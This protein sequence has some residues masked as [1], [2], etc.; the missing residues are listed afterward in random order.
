M[1]SGPY[2]LFLGRY[3]GFTEIQKLAF[4]VIEGRT[5]CI[6]TAPTGSG[7]TESAVLPVLKKILESG[8]TEGIIVLYI[9]PL[10]ALNRDLIKRLEWLSK[11]VGVN[12]GV[13]HGDTSQKERK[14]QA[15]KPPVFLITTPET[16]QNLFMSE[17]LRGS[18]KNLEYVIVDEVHELYHNKRGAQLSVALERLEE[19]SHGF[20]RIGLSATIG[21]VED[22]CAFLFGERKYELIS[23]GKSKQFDVQIEMPT[24]SRHE[25][26]EFIERFE[27]DDS[28]YARIARLAELISKSNQTLIFANTRQVVESLGNKLLY[29]EKLEPFGSIGIHHSSID[30][31]ERIET[32]NAFKEGKVKSLIATSS[33]ELGIDIGKIDLVVQ[34]GSPRQVVR[35]MQRVGRAGHKEGAVSN[36]TIIVSDFVECIESMAIISA[37]KEREL[38]KQYIEYDA[39]DVLANQICGIVLEYKKIEI[40]KIYQIIKRATPYRDTKTEKIDKVIEFLNELKIIRKVDEKNLALGFR[41]RKY[42]INNISVIPDSNRFYVKTIVGNRII[43]SLDENFVFSYLDVGATFITKGLSWKVISIEEDKIYVEPAEDIEASVPDWEGE[44]I[45]VSYNVAQRVFKL[46]NTDLNA[47]Q[48]FTEKAALASLGKFLAAQKEYFVPSV[49]TIYVEELEN[50]AIIYIALGRSANEFLAR[51]LNT[52]IIPML[53]SVV[54][55]RASPYAIIIDYSNSSRRVD[56][57]RLFGVIEKFDYADGFGIISGSDLYRYKFVQVA[58]VFGIVDKKTTVTRGIVNRLIS[59]Y[60]NSIVNDEVLRDLNKNY[61]E[62]RIVN[63]FLVELR[64][65]SITVKVAKKSGSPLSFEIL[66]AAYHHTEMLSGIEGEKEIEH[67]VKKFEGRE[68]SLICTFCGQIFSTKVDIDS[69]GPKTCPVCKSSMIVTYNEKYQTVI[70]RKVAG[71]RLSSTEQKVFVDINKEASLIQSYG[72]RA[73]VAL[74]SYGVGLETAARVLKNIR[75][76]YKTF[77]VDVIRAQ[78]T[79]VKNRKFWKA[80]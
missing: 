23:T 62:I 7:K 29:F 72:D 32:E 3:E 26:K 42:F 74:E 5:N 14:E 52:L 19:L 36:G 61:F 54:R 76:D 69:D 34:Y 78:K 1:I 79:F 71:K 6:I 56:I 41:S 2:E 47:A 67:M 13:R 43:A 59:F 38:E 45:P 46:L 80:N 49:N 53:G 30:R 20:Q 21:N 10:R 44:D 16:V 60:H 58:K 17:R 57:S 15:S 9:T 18:L 33:L 40:S 63:K 11:G 35:L 24:K 27:L 68:V 51:M 55:V 48:S 75:K 64:T 28:A 12:I 39:L 70:S 31:T 4:P 66:Q 37:A 73:L 65:G 8:K 50:Y 77:F 25:N 22:A